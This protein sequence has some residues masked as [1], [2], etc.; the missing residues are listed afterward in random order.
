VELDELVTKLV[1]HIDET[2]NTSMVPNQSVILFFIF[3][4]DR[5]LVLGCIF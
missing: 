2:A 5:F 1:K 4:I 3:A